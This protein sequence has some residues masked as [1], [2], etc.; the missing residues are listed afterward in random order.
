MVI[1]CVVLYGCETWPI[2]LSVEHRLRVFK[3][4][5]LGKVFGPDRYSSPVLLKLSRIIWARHAAEMIYKKNTYRVL[6]ESLES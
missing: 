1:I 2:T 5:V 4:V 3:N 6:W